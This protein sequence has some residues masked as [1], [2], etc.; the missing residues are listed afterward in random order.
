MPATSVFVKNLS[1]ARVLR[2]IILLGCLAF[3][4]GAVDL[5]SFEFT[6]GSGN[7]IITGTVGGFVA[8]YSI[9][10]GEVLSPL[11]GGAPTNIGW[12]TCSGYTLSKGLK[13]PLATTASDCGTVLKTYTNKLVCI[14]NMYKYTIPYI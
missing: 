14:L 9:D 10:P 3:I 2:F 7:A 6:D 12:R 11:L 1:C 13:K 4:K 5:D 8:Q